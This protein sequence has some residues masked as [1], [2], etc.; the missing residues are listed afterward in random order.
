MAGRLREAHEPLVPVDLNSF[1]DLFGM[2]VTAQRS[3]MRLYD[4]KH[5]ELAEQTQTQK[6]VMLA[7]ALLDESAE[8]KAWLPWK[9]WRLDHGRE[10]TEEER[11]GVIEELTDLLHFLLEAFIVMGVTSPREIAGYY[12]AKNRVNRARQAQGY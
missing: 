3:I 8:L 4:E 6:L 2:I 9:P 7:D 1:V 5:P 12:L 11:A 10:L